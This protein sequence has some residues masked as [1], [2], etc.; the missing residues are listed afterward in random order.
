[1]A[2][3]TTYR[4]IFKTKDNRY[5]SKVIPEPCVHQDDAEREARKLKTGDE[6]VTIEHSD[7]DQFI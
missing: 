3:P 4:A 5:Y 2:K 7:E 1:M 6:F